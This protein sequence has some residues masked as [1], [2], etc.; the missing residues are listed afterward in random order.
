M[1]NRL[2]GFHHV[3]NN[4]LPQSNAARILIK[5]NQCY[6]T[7][8]QGHGL[9]HDQPLFNLNVPWRARVY[10]LCTL[11]FAFEV[12]WLHSTYAQEPWLATFTSIIPM[13]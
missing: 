10:E 5:T 1:E 9:T 12:R 8:Y 6:L 7:G 2:H 4:K 11:K 3:S 13:R